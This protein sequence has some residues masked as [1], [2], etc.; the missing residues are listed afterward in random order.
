[1][2]N[3]VIFLG[4]LGIVAFGY[5]QYLVMAITISAAAVIVYLGYYK[6]MWEMSKFYNRLPT[7]WQ[8]IPEVLELAK[9]TVFFGDGV[10]LSSASDFYS[11]LE[12]DSS[13]F[14]IKFD[15]GLMEVFEEKYSTLVFEHH[16]V[17]PR[18]RA[19]Y[20]Y[21]TTIERHPE[22]I[23][24][25]ALIAQAIMVKKRIGGI[26]QKSKRQRIS[27]LLPVFD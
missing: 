11:V 24:R 20:H 14:E 15:I 23:D 12:D 17:S 22:D 8:D 19:L 5:G 27:L 7:T 25:L 4:L 2:K 10:D 6:A 21:F 26:R 3:L 18:V 13:N 1:M 16:P 9:E